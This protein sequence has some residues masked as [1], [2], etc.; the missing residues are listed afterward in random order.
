MNFRVSFSISVMNGYSFAS[1]STKFS[2]E[3]LGFF[4]FFFRLGERFPGLL[5]LFMLL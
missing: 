4:F 3:L 1:F 2:I 5:L